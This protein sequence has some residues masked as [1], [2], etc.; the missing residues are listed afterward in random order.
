MMPELAQL[1]SSSRSRPRALYAEHSTDSRHTLRKQCRTMLYSGKETTETL[2]ATHGRHTSISH[3][4]RA[5]GHWRKS[6]M[7]LGMPTYA[8]VIHKVAFGCRGPKGARTR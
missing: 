6:A 7:P 8:C 4:V 2:R 1:F 3:A 5:D